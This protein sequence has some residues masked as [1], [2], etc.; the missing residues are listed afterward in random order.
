MEQNPLVSV[1]INC[2]NGEQFL[3]ETIDS[4]ITQT[5]TNWEIIFW[6]NQS[7]DSTADIVK[8]YNDQR[9]KYF[10]AKVQ[11][12]LGEARNLALEKA[13]GSYIC[14]V[15]ADDWWNTDFLSVGVSN[16]HEHRCGLYY[17]NYYRVRGS[18]LKPYNKRVEEEIQTYKSLLDS[19]M[20]GMS[21]C[22]FQSDIIH[23][24]KIRFNNSYKLIE[25][26]DFFVHISLYTRV[27]YDPKVLSYYRIHDNSSSFKYRDRWY[28][29]F[30][31]FYDNIKEE[32]VPHRISENDLKN[33]RIKMEHYHAEK[34]II[35]NK[36]FELLCL[37]IRN[38]DI[39]KYL[40][41][42]NLFIFI[43]K[44]LYFNIKYKIS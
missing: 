31:N 6:D 24:N 21:A 2:Y 29:E 42:K 15:D 37:T 18:E 8:G 30:K 40:W 32:L 4:V 17:C 23:K 34:L 7:T 36:R 43:P 9:I 26:L 12:P 5:Y 33:V 35:E 44:E 20:V 10:Y 16:L 22:I 27:F 3:R 13:K 39:L 28:D 19:Y 41:K 38:I 25:D 1:I 14:F 11:T